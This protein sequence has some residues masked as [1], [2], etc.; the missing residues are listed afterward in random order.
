MLLHMYL[1]DCSDFRKF[2]FHKVV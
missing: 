2:T 1:T